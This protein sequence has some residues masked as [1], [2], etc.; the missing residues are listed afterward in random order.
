MSVCVRR[1]VCKCIRKIKET[2]YFAIFFKLKKD[3]LRIKGIK[4]IFF[5]FNFY[6]FQ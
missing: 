2:D 1:S 4:K 6:C 5:E 3:S